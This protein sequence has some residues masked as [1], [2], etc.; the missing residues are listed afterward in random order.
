MPFGVLRR[1]PMASAKRGARGAVIGRQSL[2]SYYDSILRCDLLEG[3]CV[4][5]IC[6]RH[7]RGAVEPDLHVDLS[8]AVRRHLTVVRVD[9]EDVARVHR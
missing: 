9:S 4:R 6:E 2:V 7:G 1:E 3:A 8:V 5:G